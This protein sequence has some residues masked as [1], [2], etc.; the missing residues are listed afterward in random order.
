MK[1]RAFIGSVG[2]ISGASLLTGNSQADDHGNATSKDERLQ[3]ESRAAFDELISTLQAADLQFLGKEGGI[4]RAADVSDGHRAI[5]HTLQWSLVSEMDVSRDHPIFHRIVTPTRKGLGDNPDAVYF[6]ASIRGVRNYTIRSNMAGAVYTS[7]TIEG[8]AGDGSYATGVVAAINNTEFDVSEDGS[9]ELRLG[10]NVS[11]RNSLKLPDN[12]AQ[13]TT[14]HYF[15]EEISV[16]ADLGRHIPMTIE[17][18][19]QLPPPPTP[20]DASI[21]AG[22]RRVT[23]QVAGRTLGMME[24]EKESPTWVSR[25]P[26]HFMPPEKPGN[27]AFSAVDNAY[28]MAPYYLGDDEAL[29]ITGRFPKCAFANVALWNRFLQSYDYANRRISLNRVQTKTDTEG[30]FRMV[31]AHNDPGV[32]NW[33]D[34]EGRNFG[35]VY[36]RFLLPEGDIVT[37]EAEVVKFSTITAS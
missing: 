21:A 13:I 30:N 26:N 24:R 31:L 11:G 15:E 37:P 12:A 17:P 34:T 10:P 3:T 8:G 18:T 14:R 7:I 22:I 33:I 36:W 2:A 35:M 16:A 28:S 9:F 20:D 5:M 25:I 4:T 29:I 19:D 1:R 23:A 32:P 27:M 6:N